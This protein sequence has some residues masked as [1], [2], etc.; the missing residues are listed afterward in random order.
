MKVEEVRPWI[1]EISEDGPSKV[2][3]SSKAEDA[4]HHEEQL[5]DVPERAVFEALLNEDAPTDFLRA[6]DIGDSLPLP[7]FSVKQIQEAQAIGTPDAGTT[8]KEV[9][10]FRGSFTGVEDATDLCDASSLFDEAQRLSNQVSLSS[11][12]QYYVRIH[13]YFLD[14]LFFHRP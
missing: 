12:H 10:L 2:P 5:A 7:T 9:D 1:E 4:S 8:P 13:F 14:F 6:I 3:K 11:L